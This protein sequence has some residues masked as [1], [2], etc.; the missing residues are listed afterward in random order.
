MQLYSTENRKAQI[1][2]HVQQE[3]QFII[4]KFEHALSPNKKWTDL[5][6][7]L[8]SRRVYLNKPKVSTSPGNEHWMPPTHNKLPFSHF[9]SLTFHENDLYFI[10]VSPFLSFSTFL[11]HHILSFRFPP[12]FPAISHGL[13]ICLPV[14]FFTSLCIFTPLSLSF[15]CSVLS[16]S[17]HKTLLPPAAFWRL[18]FHLHPSPPHSLPPF[19]ALS[20]LD[21]P[22]PSSPNTTTSLA[23]TAVHSIFLHMRFA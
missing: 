3:V 2:A 21:N 9:L 12:A 5:I 18:S 6:W 20:P 14:F 1:K 4:D 16:L 23:L 13:C 11:R 8:F 22:H 7:L 10:S 19:P 15:C 17:P